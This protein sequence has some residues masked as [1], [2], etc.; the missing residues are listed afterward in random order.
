MAD[1]VLTGLVDRFAATRTQIDERTQAL[2]IAELSKFDGWYSPRLVEEITS[3][4]AVHVTR[5]QLATAALTDAYLAQVTTY[6]TG[7]YTVGAQV[8]AVMGRTLRTGPGS[9]EE[10]YGRVAAEFRRHRAAGKPTGVALGLAMDRTGRMVSTDMGLAFQHQTRRFSNVR[11]LRAFRRV[12]RPELSRTGSCGLC[13]AASDRVYRR[14]DLMPLHARCKCTVIPITTAADPGSQL[15][16]D[17]LGDLYGAAGSTYGADLK[18]TRFVIVE[19]GEL[20]P[21]LRRQGDHFRGPG[22]VREAA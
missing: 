4:V 12:V 20:G 5:G 6:V 13:V 11:P 14:G 18:R 19:H 9:H 17:T 21:Q 7:R 15:N 8:P 22:Q 2:V 1:R 10:V 3:A 16:E